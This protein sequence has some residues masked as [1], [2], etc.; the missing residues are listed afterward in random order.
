M[1]A[2]P[3]PFPKS[4]WRQLPADEEHG[5]GD[6]DHDG[7]GD[8]CDGCP[9][10]PR[11]QC[12]RSAWNDKDADGIPDACD[13]YPHGD[14]QSIL[15]DGVPSAL[16]DA[17]KPNNL[18]RASGAVGRAPDILQHPHT[19]L[20]PGLPAVVRSPLPRETGIDRLGRTHSHIGRQRCRGECD[21][22]QA[23]GRRRD[24]TFRPLGGQDYYLVF[25]FT[26]AFGTPSGAPFSCDCR[27]VGSGTLTY[28]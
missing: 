17:L 28:F 4:C 18:P 6:S 22:V 9:E 23:S 13:P 10:T 8:A 27:L 20:H 1:T 24:L 21:E 7:L 19:C 26:P 15:L 3:I 14:D 25:A 2:C 12:R 16:A 5:S 11:T